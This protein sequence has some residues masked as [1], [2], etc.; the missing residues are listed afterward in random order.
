MKKILMV[1]CYG[2]GRGGVQAVMM[3]IIRN[4]KKTCNYDML[5]FTNEV[6][7]YEDEFLQIGGGIF[8]VPFYSGKNQIRRRLDYYIR[9]ISLYKKIKKIIEE[10]G[11]YD[12]IH[13]NNQMEAGLCLK[14]ARKTRFDS[15]VRKI[16][17]RREW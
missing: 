11:P 3:D 9:G 4:T 10:H 1:S 12:A 8:R 13:C 16:P 7:Y 17:W 2:L 6:M 5:L 15:W 14:A